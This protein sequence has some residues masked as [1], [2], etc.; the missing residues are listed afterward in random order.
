[1][2][3]RRTFS[4]RIP[5]TRMCCIACLPTISLYFI[6]N[7]RLKNTSCTFLDKSTNMLLFTMQLLATL[8]VA[9]GLHPVRGNWETA[10]VSP[11]WRG[12]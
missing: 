10:R 12:S 8:V 4:E 2:S 5:E 7:S 6:Q 3:K 9:V 1:M 11:P